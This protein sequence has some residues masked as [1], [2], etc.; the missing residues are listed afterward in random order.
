LFGRLVGLVVQYLMFQFPDSI[1][2]YA[3]PAEQSPFECV[4]PGI[5]AM[6]GAAAALAGV[7]R[8]TVSLAVISILFPLARLTIVFELTGSLTYV[9][10]IMVAILVSKWVSE[11]IEKQGIYDLVIELNNHPYLDSKRSHVF[12][13]TFADLCTAQSEDD[14]NVI[15]VTGGKH[16]AADVLREKVEWLKGIGGRDGGFPI[17]K[18]GVLVGYLSASELEYALGLLPPHLH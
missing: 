16:V 3:C 15:D 4:V 9:M 2:F 11:A 10:P 1:F 14:R 6:V 8:M 12:T 5:Y 13:S 18:R 7:T 17:I